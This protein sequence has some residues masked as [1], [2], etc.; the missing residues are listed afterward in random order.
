MLATASRALTI[1]GLGALSIAALAHAP[2][3]TIPQPG[4]RPPAAEAGAFIASL[5]GATVEVHPAMVRRADRTAFS[6]SSQHQFANA[7]HATGLLTA[8]TTAHRPRIGQGPLRH[9]SQGAHFQSTLAELAGALATRPTDADYRLILEFLVPDPQ[10]VFGIQCYILDR[11]GRNAFSFLLNDHHAMF[12]EAHLHTKDSSEPA[13]AAMIADA[14]RV[15][16]AALQAQILQARECQQRMAADPALVVREGVLEHFDS[17]LP[18]GTDPHG[19][20]LGYSTF[21]DP[22]SKVAVTTTTVHPD[23]PGESEGNTVL[24]LDM[25]VS[26]WAGVASLFTDEAAGRWIAQDWRA[27]EAFSFWLYGTGGGNTLFVDVID[28]RNPCSEGDD[29][30]RYVWTFTDDMAGWRQVTIRFA[31]M[32]RKEIG[33][34]APDDGLGL[35]RVHGW[36]FG[37]TETDGQVTYYLD[38]FALHRAEQE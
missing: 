34:W 18:S 17:G 32:T 25:T 13:R 16:G 7:L 24:Q 30:E 23:R 21:S 11:Q 8:T 14:T 2:E 33:N 9:Q 12:A 37:S 28:N 29:A 27:F 15:A 1:L 5:D 36:G 19:V 38:D 35:A 22:A 31:D 26:G 3:E 10:S 4:F 20:P 6:T